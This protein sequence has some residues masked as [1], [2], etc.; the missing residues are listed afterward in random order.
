MSAKDPDQSTD[1]PEAPLPRPERQTGVRHF[2]AAACHSA[3]GL[4]RLWGEAAFRHELMAA[5]AVV[6]G[7]ALI[8]AS[9][10]EILVAIILILLLIATEALNTALE[11]IVDHVSPGWAE[12]ARDA[13]DLGS[14]A[15]MCLLLANGAWLIS[16]LISL[17]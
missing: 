4:K 11:A 14:L 17:L 13:K 9:L 10:F 1:G 6:A 7:L 12:F 8:G 16:V 3:A 15:V 5:I 2:F